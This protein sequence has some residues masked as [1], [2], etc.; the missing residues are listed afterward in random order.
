MAIHFSFSS[1]L[2]S[3]WLSPGKLPQHVHEIHQARWAVEGIVEGWR[4]AVFPDPH[5]PGLGNRWRYFL[6]REDP[7]VSRLSSLR[8][9]YLD[10]LYFNI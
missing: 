10:H 9:L 5:P 8:Q 3:N 1:H 4:I 6:A 7:A 2:D